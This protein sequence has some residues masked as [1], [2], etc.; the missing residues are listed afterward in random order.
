[1]LVVNLFGAPGAGKS[2]GA[3]YVFSMLKMLGV[4]AELVTEFAKDKVWEENKTAFD[5]HAYIFGEQF[6]RLS[7]LEGKVEVAITDSP[8]ALSVLYNKNP[9]L[10]QTFDDF[11]FDVAS[12]YD[13]LNAFI[14]RAKPYNNQG[15]RESERE[16]DLVSA[17]LIKLL[18]ARDVAYETYSGNVEGYDL[19]V[20]DVLGRL[21]I[22]CGGLDL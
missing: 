3:A 7:R 17:E 15:R 2:T 8:L 20:G 14:T 22:V 11:V 16:S 9:I 5:N 6:Y 1:V 21:G 13:S 18:K 12:S 10:R 4:N 19:L